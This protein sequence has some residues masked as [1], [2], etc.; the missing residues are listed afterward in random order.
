M[1][2]TPVPVL[3]LILAITTPLSYAQ[4]AAASS[5]AALSGE[6]V[7]II[8]TETDADFYVLE[9]TMPGSN[10]SVSV[11]LGY[12]E[13][14]DAA[15]LF[16]PGKLKSALEL[17]GELVY[18]FPRTPARLMVRGYYTNTDLE[19]GVRYSNNKW[20]TYTTQVFGGDYTQY[21]L[22]AELRFDCYKKESLCA[23]FSLG[24]IFDKTDVAKTGFYL[25]E[26]S[27]KRE[28]VHM[29]NREDDGFGFIGHLGV[30]CLFLDYF[31]LNAEVGYLTEIYSEHVAGKYQ[32]DIRGILGWWYSDFGRVDL[33]A[34][35]LTEWEALHAG[36]QL[37]FAF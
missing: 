1:K 29:S 14:E 32:F 31:Y 17:N 8:P 26:Y 22:T 23:Y 7:L 35:Y 34:R 24:S 10:V 28:L 27:A 18:S 4:E 11:G 36:A 33:Y 3:T 37:T 15:G 16:K 2:Y 19:E 12:F 5:S 9:P 21:G 20:G 25:R 30:E 6:S 13:S